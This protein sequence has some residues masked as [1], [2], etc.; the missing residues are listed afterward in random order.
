MT[1]ESYD[2]LAEEEAVTRLI[3]KGEVLLPFAEAIVK[4][5]ARRG[6]KKKFLGYVLQCICSARAYNL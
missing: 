2:Q 5:L 4:R 6:V 3:Q 1:F